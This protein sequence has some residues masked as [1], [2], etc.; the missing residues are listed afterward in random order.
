MEWIDGNI[1]S[2]VNIPAC[3]LAGEGAKAPLSIAVA[4]KFNT[5][6]LEQE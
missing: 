1:G 5:K 6:M 3:I 2:R 4:G